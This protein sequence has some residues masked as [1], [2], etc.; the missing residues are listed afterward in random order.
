IS[1]TLSFGTT[2]LQGATVTLWRSTDQSTWNNVANNTIAD[3]GSYQFSRNESIANTYYYHTT[4]AGNDTYTNV[5][6]NVTQLSVTGSTS[7]L[8][9]FYVLGGLAVVFAIV[10][11]ARE[12]WAKR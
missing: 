9:A 7:G 10:L 4:Y 11:A 3:D 1:G 5:T 12:R 8:E 6:S 2:N